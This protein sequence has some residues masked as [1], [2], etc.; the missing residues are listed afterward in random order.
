MTGDSPKN[1]PAE[2]RAQPAYDYIVIGSGF[3]GSVSALR[4]S[5]KG[6]RVAVVEMGRRWTANDFPKTNWN[7]R[8][9][10]WAPALRLWGFFRMTVFG[11]AWV[12]SGVGVGGGS[13]VY[14]NTLLVP[15]DRVWDDP[16]W[17]G[18]ND[19][20]QTMPTHYATAKRMLGVTQNPYM[21]QADKLLKAAADKQGFG[22]SHYATDVA[23]YFG[24]PGETVA[25]P[26]FGGKGPARTACIYC[27]G[28]MVGC[29]HGAKNTLDKNYLFLAEAQGAKVIAETRV[30]DVQPLG[31]ADGSDGYV[32]T[33]E[34]SRRWLF[35]RRTTLTAKGVVF[36]GGVLGTVP[37][38][39]DLKRRGSLGRLSAC[40]GDYVRTNSESIIGV[41]M[42]DRSLDVSDGIAIG[43]GIYIDEHTH[44]E[45][46]RYPKGSDAMG[47]TATLLTGGTPGPTR[48]LTWLG[49]ALRHPFKFLRSLVPFGFA[50][51]SII[52]LV[53]QT[54]DGHLKL[55][56]KRSWLMPW[57]RKLTT[58]GDKIPTYIPQA[59][60][61]AERMAADLDATPMT[62]LTEI[63]LNVPTTA[64]IL[65]GAPMGPDADQGVIDGQNRVYGYNNMYVC[66]GSAI[67]ANLGVNPSLTIT[68]LTEHAM[69]F[70]PAKD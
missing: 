4:L 46:V 65:G 35:K 57:R 19:W 49:V 3:G 48:I 60:A 31:A 61:F 38:L 14:A 51:N 7:I 5:E 2:G 63:L 36:S 66:D 28:C 43:S 33:V 39:F 47:L 34:P 21:G 12:L 26:Y 22:A 58:A 70:V 68:A 42:H 1:T 64:H 59:N 55:K 13:L 11:H 27:G 24:K 41:R 25:D 37:L 17:A 50:K 62:A 20:R 45:A 10:I 18:L 15:P 16:R 67:G 23:V 52:L 29:R 30:V 9:F 44:I 6:Y 56:M 32:V 69:S 53:M 40:I 8:N 54:L